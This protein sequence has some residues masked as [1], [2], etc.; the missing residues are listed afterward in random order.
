MKQDEMTELKAWQKALR[1]E[2]S[3]GQLSNN[4]T[5][6]TEA[7]R[8]HVLNENHSQPKDCVDETWQLLEKKLEAEHEHSKK[9]EVSLFE[10]LWMYIKEPRF[11]LPAALTVVCVSLFVPKLFMLTD[12]SDFETTYLNKG[13][14]VTSAENT[15]NDIQL[16]KV[17]LTKKKAIKLYDDLKSI[18]GT[19]NISDHLTFQFELNGTQRTIGFSTETINSEA[20]IELLIQYNEIPAFDI[21]TQQKITISHE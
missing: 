2:A 15:A 1:G 3:S 8:Q 5:Q 11:L 14:T 4:E 21:S 16:N 19:Q 17:L 20:M 7:I 18:G 6:F 10:T 13:G 12:K 9:K